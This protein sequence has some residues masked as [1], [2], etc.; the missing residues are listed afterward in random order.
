MTEK[1]KKESQSEMVAGKVE[2]Q[3]A[4][5]ATTSSTAKINLFREAVR[6]VHV[7]P[8]KNGWEVFR[9]GTEPQQYSNRGEAV[10]F[11]KLIATENNIDVLIHESGHAK[12]LD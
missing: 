2:L 9:V 5:S 4:G 8:N 7:R 12:F 3:A 6:A 1:R 11:A 10:N